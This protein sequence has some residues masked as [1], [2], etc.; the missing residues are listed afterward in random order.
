[1]KLDRSQLLKEIKEAFPEIRS[2]INSEEGLLH[3][4]VGVF[5]QFTQ[6]IINEGEREK[7]AKSFEIAN[8]YYLGGNSKVQN[9]I[10]VS[11]VEG[12]EFKNTKKNIREWAWE[13]F[14]ER[15]KTEYMEFHGRAGT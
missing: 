8:R 3:L 6:K 11:Y 5:Y 1:M 15:L 12:L 9:A 4:E 14:P 2:E 10:G 13:I 7:V